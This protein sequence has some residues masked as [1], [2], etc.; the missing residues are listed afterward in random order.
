VIKAEKSSLQSLMDGGGA[1]L[2]DASQALERVNRTL[3]D[4]NIENVSAA[5]ANVTATTAE[6]RSR[7]PP[8]ESRLVGGGFAR[9]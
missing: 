6:L 9:S 2:A 7:Y 3:S 1:L 5:I 8:G 4:E